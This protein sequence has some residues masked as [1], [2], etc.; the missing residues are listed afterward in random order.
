MNILDTPYGPYGSKTQFY[1]STIFGGHVGWDKCVQ[2]YM[3]N[4]EHSTDTA[5]RVD[6]GDVNKPN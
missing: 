4:Q 6:C 5:G 3:S 1:N 2:G